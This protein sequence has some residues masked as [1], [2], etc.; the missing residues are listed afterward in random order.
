MRGEG[1]NRY[2]KSRAARPD[3][4]TTQGVQMQGVICYPLAGPTFRRTKPNVKRAV[5]TGRR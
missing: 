4:F 1:F 3:F 5:V 2:K